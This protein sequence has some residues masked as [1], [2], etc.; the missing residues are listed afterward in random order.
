M[1]EQES[2]IDH[3]TQPGE[4]VASISTTER[5]KRR[6]ELTEEISPDCPFEKELQWAH[7]VEDDFDVMYQKNE[8]SYHP[9]SACPAR[10]Q[11]RLAPKLTQKPLRSDSLHYMEEIDEKVK[12]VAEYNEADTLSVDSAFKRRGCAME[13]GGVMSRLA[14][15][16]IRHELMR[17]WRTPPRASHLSGMC[18]ADIEAA[19]EA[20]WL[21][22]AEVADENDGIQPISTPACGEPNDKRRRPC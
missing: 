2:R 17:V 16:K 18:L 6:Q 13:I 20:I 11:E 10:D 7:C 12:P 4:I 21:R 9:L 22:M 3:D 19:D 15:D 8:L 1:L 5:R 14:H